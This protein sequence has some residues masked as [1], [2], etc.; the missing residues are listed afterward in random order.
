MV[1]SKHGEKMST[2]S[3]LEQLLNLLNK[4]NALLTFFS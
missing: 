2:C 3:S 4:N 1:A